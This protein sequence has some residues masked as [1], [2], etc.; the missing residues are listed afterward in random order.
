VKT[1]RVV[2]DAAPSDRSGRWTT[3]VV[4][5]EVGTRSPETDPLTLAVYEVQGVR[6]QREAIAVAFRWLAFDRP[7]AM[8]VRETYRREPGT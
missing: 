5:Y 8:T 6:T 1:F 7:S 3:N 2:M 4:A